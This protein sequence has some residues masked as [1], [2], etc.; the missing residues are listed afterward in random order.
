MPLKILKCDKTIKFRKVPKSKYELDD[1]KERHYWKDLI[2]LV[3]KNAKKVGL[4]Y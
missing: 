1:P 4:N 3:E 2:D